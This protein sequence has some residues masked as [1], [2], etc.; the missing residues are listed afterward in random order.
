MPLVARVQ[1]G[2][3]VIMAVRSYSKAARAARDMGMDPSSYTIMNL[4][5]ASLDSVRDFVNNVRLVGR[6]VDAV[7]CNAAVWY[8][9]DKEPRL[10]VDGFEEVPLPSP[11]FFA[12]SS[13]SSLFLSLPLLCLARCLRPRPVSASSFRMCPPRL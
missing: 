9:M 2:W 1:K 6:Q 4:D 11:R 3:H 13:L 12:A 8:P 5:M 7:V 10:T